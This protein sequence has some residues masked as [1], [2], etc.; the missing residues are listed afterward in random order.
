MEVRDIGIVGSLLGIIGVA[1]GGGIW[2]GE[3]QAT[4]EELKR[5]VQE[6][7][8]GQKNLWK[9][10]NVIHEIKKD[11]AVLDQRVD[12]M[13]TRQRRIEYKVDTGFEKVIEEIQRRKQ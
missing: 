3:T 1:I 12:D 6:L 4:A 7:K 2:I 5:Q 13:D 11:Q 10:Q 8:Q 9:R